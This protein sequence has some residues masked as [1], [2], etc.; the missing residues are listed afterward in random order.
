MGDIDMRVYVNIEDFYGKTFEKVYEKNGEIYF[1]ENS[2]CHYVMTYVQCCCES[3]SLEDINGSLDSLIG[4]P[5]LVAEE[6]TNQKDGGQSNDYSYTW[7]FY[8]LATVKGW[9]DIRWYGTS[10]GYYSESVDILKIT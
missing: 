9:V 10:N 8:K 2:S 5:I 1:V 4:T 6:S 3:V 7:T